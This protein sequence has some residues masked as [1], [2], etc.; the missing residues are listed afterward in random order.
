ML[1]MWEKEIH[2]PEAQQKM[3]AYIKYVYT[4]IVFS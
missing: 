3:T 2:A 1:S 4:N